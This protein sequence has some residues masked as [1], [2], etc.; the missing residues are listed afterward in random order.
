MKIMEKQTSSHNHPILRRIATI[1]V[2]LVILA[3]A[4]LLLGSR[5]MMY[6]S[7]TD[8]DHMDVTISP[9]GTT[10]TAVGDDSAAAVNILSQTVCYYPQQEEVAGQ[11]VSLD[12]YMHDGTIMTVTACGNHFTIDGKS[13][14]ARLSDGE[15]L[16]DW[17]Q[18][19]AEKQGSQS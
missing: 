11:S 6:L 12:I 4:R 17:A 9:S 1:L 3:A 16:E 2:V 13:Y 19:L 7:A 18:A 5:Q 15:A 10:V 14:K 8:I